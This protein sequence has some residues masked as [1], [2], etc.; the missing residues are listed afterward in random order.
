MFVTNWHVC[1]C[2]CVS[3]CERPCVF[4]AV[5]LS[6]VVRLLSHFHPAV[7][8]TQQHSAKSCYCCHCVEAVCISHCCFQLLLS[9][10]QVSI[11]WKPKP[12]KTVML[13]KRGVFT[14]QWRLITQTIIHY[15][16]PLLTYSISP[17]LS[18]NSSPLLVSSVRASAKKE[19]WKHAPDALLLQKGPLFYM[20]LLFYL[21]FWYP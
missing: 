1:L 9:E 3:A 19:N 8:A 2:V 20:F 5:W 14:L 21:K 13:L 12:V 6:V 10:E 18:A 4:L 11:S 16:F 17:Q 7:C 15:L